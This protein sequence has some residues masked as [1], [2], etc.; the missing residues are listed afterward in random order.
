M[1]TGSGLC[2][3]ELIYYSRMGSMFV[4]GKGVEL[5][6]VF[7]AILG[8][9]YVCVWEGG[10]AVQSFFYYSRTGVCLCTG[11]GLS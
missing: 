5:Y 6:R 3:T 2:C 11:K 7:F 9:E 1:C 8:R 10:W 4:Y